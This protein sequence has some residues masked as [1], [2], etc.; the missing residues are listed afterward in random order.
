MI[1]F[2][3]YFKYIQEA[4]LISGILGLSFVIFLPIGFHLRFAV[5]LLLAAVTYVNYT[6]S[7]L[8]T[9]RIIF[10]IV[11][12]HEKSG[13]LGFISYHASY[14]SDITKY[15]FTQ[16]H[17]IDVIVNIACGS[18]PLIASHA[19]AKRYFKNQNV[20]ANLL[21]AAV[22]CLSIYSTLG[23][24]I[25]ILLILSIS[26]RES[27]MV[28]QIVLTG[29]EA[30]SDMLRG[31]FLINLKLIFYNKDGIKIHENIRIPK[32]FESRGIII[33]GAPG[34][35][36][37]HLIKNHFIPQIRARK[38]H[39]IIYDYKG[40]FTEAIGEEKDV[41]IVSPLDARSGI[42]DIA[43]DIDTEAKAF[44]FC[45]MVV[46]SGDSTHD[47]IFEEWSRDL[48]TAGLIRLQVEKKGQFTFADFYYSCQ[49]LQWLISAVKTYRKEAE[50][51]A[52]F[53]D[54]S[55]QFEAV[56][57]TI[58]RAMVRLEPLVRAWANPKAS[59]LF[60]L[61][62]WLD[63]ADV[64][65]KVLLIRDDPL[66]KESIGPFTSNFVN[67]LISVI[68]SK[69]DA[70]GA[71]SQRRLWIVLDEFQ[72]LP[73]IPKLFDGARAGRSKGLR[74]ILGTQ[75][76]GRVDSMYRK[77]GS[78][79]T[80]L[81]LIGFKLVGHLGSQGMQEFAAG[82][83]GKNDIEVE[84]KSVSYAG[85]KA[86]VSY[87]KTRES[88]DAIAP[89]EFATIELPTALNGSVFWLIHQGWNPVKLRYICKMSHDK[90]EAKVDEKWLSDTDR[91]WGD[92]GA[93]EAAKGEGDGI[94]EPGGR[95]HDV[96]KGKGAKEGLKGEQDADDDKEKKDAKSKIG[97][98]MSVE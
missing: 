67:F 35:G 54:D 79:D 56:K 11:K 83:F 48:L 10:Y 66:Y 84:K 64:E 78:R 47:P 6:S 74:F 20:Y 25:I 82:L 91:L 51:A 58:R 18:F 61:S 1:E 43:K 87:Q 55:R 16:N 36:K 90:Y 50:F 70:K 88:R 59:R 86:T 93:H 12:H 57:G 37:S 89:G 73:K 81:N 29:K 42:W 15:I 31:L 3:S 19:I 65:K 95:T 46:Q 4:A 27:T 62:D 98:D 28:V 22:L 2:F 17:G 69:S 13:F 49:N 92:D 53:S 97:I 30:I 8:E 63:S 60:S 40:E 94:A 52:N 72:L 33:F 32:L 85:S 21:F 7:A 41:L 24:S 68:L 26:T 9:F 44:E 39:A 38:D 23:L 76:L 5:F 14:F 34:S 71:S 45:A 77:D 75:D 96:A 80:L